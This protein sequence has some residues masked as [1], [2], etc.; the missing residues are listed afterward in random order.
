[1]LFQI[2]TNFLPSFV[3]LQLLSLVFVQLEIQLANKGS[4]PIMHLVDVNG[5]VVS[6]VSYN[7]DHL[8]NG[9]EAHNMST[10][11]QYYWALPKEFLGNKVEISCIFYQSVLLRNVIVA[12]IFNSL[13]TPA[14]YFAL[15]K[16]RITIFW[17]FTQ[18]CV[19]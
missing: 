15:K 18:L 6:G 1:M 10:E 5:S 12:R 19:R 14:L 11:T 8:N 2:Q 17:T 3:V 4:R 7:A 9:L 13:F 16:K